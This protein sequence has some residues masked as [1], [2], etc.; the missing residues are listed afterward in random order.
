MKNVI[1]LFSVLIILASCKKETFSVSGKIEN[2]TGETI[3]FQRLDLNK[4]E[5]IDSM[6]VKK[7]GS[8][9]FTSKRLAEPTF[10]Q[11]TIQPNKNLVLLADST[12][13]I[14]VYAD[15]KSFDTTVKISQSL[16]SQE[17][18]KINNKGAQLQKII[19]SKLTTIEK[20]SKENV[21][22]REKILDE[23]NAEI[24]SHKKYIYDYIFDNPRSF[25]SYY[26]L[27][28][29]ILNV[30]LFDVMHQK[31]H[32][33]FATLATSLNLLYPNSERVKHLYQYVLDAKATMKK[34][35]INNLLLS[36]AETVGTPEIE[37]VDIHGKKVKLSDLRGKVVLLS[38]WAAWD[39]ASRKENKNLLNIY[40]KYHNKGFEI[41]QVSLDKSKVLWESATKQ[42][43]LP[44]IQV[45]D[46]KYTSSYWARLYNINK[47]PANYLISKNGELIGKDLFGTMLDE[48]I[49]DA[50]K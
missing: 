9:K 23:I 2:A 5:I 3:I 36:N 37:E 14:L 39:E 21:A 43:N 25:V 10:F 31:D 34:Q 20:L 38:F 32:I 47:I 13:N 24:E 48:K 45:S 11:I 33:S 46:L 27:F 12:E 30:P 49:A 28:Q 16:G 26:A 18:Y 15:V 29:N 44:W 41:F 6:K 4:N 42:D 7:D 22:E 35:Q 1:L 17:L 50:L 19:Q 40:N 8:F